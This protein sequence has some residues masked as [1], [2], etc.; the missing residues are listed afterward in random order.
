MIRTFGIRCMYDIPLKG[1]FEELVNVF[2]GTHTEALLY[3]EDMTSIDPYSLWT[4]VE[5]TEEEAE[6]IELKLKRGL[7]EK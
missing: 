7:N 3:I 2:R 1:K 6:A 5:I 4:F